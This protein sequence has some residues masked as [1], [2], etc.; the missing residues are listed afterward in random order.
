MAPP[1]ESA[2]QGQAPQAPPSPMF[3]APK[4][5]SP[6]V[7]GQMPVALPAQGTIPAEAANQAV[8]IPGLPKIGPAIKLAGPMTA[9]NP[10]SLAPAP[11]PAATPATAPPPAA[12][13]PP[14]TEAPWIRAA[15]EAG[16][17][18]DKLIDVAARHPESRDFI[19][20][21]LKKAFANQG[22]Q[23]EANKIFKDASAGDVK[24]QNKIFQMIKPETGKPKEEVTTGDYVRAYMY[25]RLGL[26]ALA[27]DIQNK[28]IGK[29]TKFG[30]VSIGGSNWQVETDPSGQIIRARD[31]EGNVATEATLNRLRAAGMKTG[32]QVFGFTGEAAVI[33]PGQPDAG[34]E[35]RQR[36]N[37]VSGQIENVITSGPNANKIYS[38]PPGPARSVGTAALKATD[39]KQI[40]LA[41]D[42]IIDAAK[43]GAGYLGEF[44][45]KYGTNFNILGYGQN[46][47]PIVV[48]RTTN[49]VLSKNDQG[50][51]TTTSTGPGK[52]GAAAA[53]SG[54]AANPTVKVL[55]GGG[56]KTP[57]Q[58]EQSMALGKKQGE[59][60]IDLAK[61]VAAAE[62]KV[63]AEAKG[64]IQ[65]KDINNQN[66]ANST[67]DLVKPIADLIKKSTGSGI[68]VG[69]DKLAGLI[70]ASNTGAEAIAELEVLTYPLVSNVPRFEGPQG[71]R[72]VELY[73]RAAGDLGNGNKPVK[74][75]LAALNAMITMLKKY[76]KAGT[77]D[78]TFG[79]TGAAGGTTSTN[80]KYKVIN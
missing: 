31:D 54:T 55:T 48:D 78:W 60:N 53:A 2:P 30:Q 20:D 73:E 32:G 33:P 66:F 17:D 51:V 38:G 39:A 4:P 35:Y 47:E 19:N 24:A 34:Q 7:P 76:D 72:D 16:T 26:D 43:R 61:E 1:P 68:G 69:V 62:Q 12:A 58:I 63:P 9:V 64:K 13:P 11:A 45:A 70:G 18:F 46:K 14:A 42:P 21:K 3:M 56:G 27:Q 40:S 23:E 59:A 25:K 50:V 8:E 22:K 77:N 10:A 41:Y 74:V 65:A 6:A 15:N 29:E 36:T 44:N 67:Y 57:A 28:I 71:V 37:A 80:V 75:R 49:Q 5:P 52:P 79:G